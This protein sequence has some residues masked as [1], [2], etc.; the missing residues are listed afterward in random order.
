MTAEL[1]FVQK[2]QAILVTVKAENPNPSAIDILDAMR[3]ALSDDEFARLVLAG[4][5]A[6]GAGGADEG[7]TALRRRTRQP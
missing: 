1:A 2:L 6:V 3:S 7:S 4:L 5:E